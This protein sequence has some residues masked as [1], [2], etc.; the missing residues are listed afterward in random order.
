LPRAISTLLVLLSLQ[1]DQMKSCRR[2]FYSGC[3]NFTNQPFAVRQH[4]DL[5]VL[6]SFMQFYMC[7]RNVRIYMYYRHQCYATDVAASL[8][9]DCMT[10]AASVYLLLTSRDLQLI[11]VDCE[12]SI[13]RLSSPCYVRSVAR[14][15]GRPH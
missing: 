2:H 14:V 7:R 11:Y 6:T 13:T 8:L 9:T 5:S 12:L 4:V 1:P 15:V 10:V 3:L